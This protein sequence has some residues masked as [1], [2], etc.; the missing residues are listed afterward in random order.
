LL[1]SFERGYCFYLLEFDLPFKKQVSDF[2]YI[3]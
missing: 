1:H 3:L 2:P